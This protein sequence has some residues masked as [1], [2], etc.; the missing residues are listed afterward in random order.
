M[1]RSVVLTLGLVVSSHVALGFSVSGNSEAKTSQLSMTSS[2]DE[3]DSRRDFFT[4]TAGMAV[5]G[6]G[7][8]FLPMDAANAVSGAN[9]VNAKLKG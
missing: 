6:F 9:K 3:G 2:Q 8:P 5:A 7:V 4:K 1:F